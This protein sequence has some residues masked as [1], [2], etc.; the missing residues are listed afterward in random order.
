MLS[1]RARIS[2]YNPISPFFGDDGTPS[3][4]EP[5]YPWL[6]PSGLAQTRSAGCFH[7]LRRR[8]LRLDSASAA[9]ARRSASRAS[10][11]ATLVRRAAAVASY[12]RSALTV[13]WPRKR[14]P[15]LGL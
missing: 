12:L 3:H 8:T 1:R 11:S 10:R 6:L 14:N 2:K 7:S 5:L 13:N 9:A 15:C 4:S